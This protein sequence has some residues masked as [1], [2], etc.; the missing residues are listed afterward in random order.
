M[1]AAGSVVSC[2]SVRLGADACGVARKQRNRFGTE[3][4]HCRTGSGG[5]TWSTF[6][7]QTGAG[8]ERIAALPTASRIAAVPASEIAPGSVKPAT[9]S[10]AVNL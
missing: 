1:V 2:G 8:S 9:V 5:M 10:A 4:T 3:I 7:S 6:Q